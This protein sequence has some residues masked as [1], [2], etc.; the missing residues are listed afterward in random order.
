MDIQQEINSLREE[1]HRHNIAYYD[2]DAPTIS[3]F[4][5]D[6]LM[7]RLI[8]LETAHPELI[9][10]DSPTQRVGG[11]ASRRFAEVRHEVPLE[12]L[13]DVFSREETEAFL[14][15]V[16]ESEPE[17]RFTVEPK[18]DG[19]SVAVEYRGGAL[20]RGATRGDGITG[21]DVTANLMTVRS[22]P[23]RIESA[24]DRIIVRGEVYMSKE[25]F[26]ELNLEREVRGEA[27][28]A[29]PRNAA[30]GSH[31]ILL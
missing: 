22:L 5:Y 21:E 12:S 31:I 16:C 3:D 27:L 15:R 14:A 20:Y 24:P 10:P 29:N 17:A 8:E 11:S 2:N 25:V 26:A 7:R 4:E 19:L 9:T 18:V 28:L 1:I 23:K 6:A 13:M 30:A